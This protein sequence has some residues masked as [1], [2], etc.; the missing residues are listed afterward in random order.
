MRPNPRRKGPADRILQ[1]RIVRVLRVKDTREY[2]EGPDGKF[3]P[4]PGSGEARDC[5]RCGREHR[6]HAEVELEDHS[7]AI[8]GTGC[9]TQ[10]EMDVSKRVKAAERVA[11]RIRQTEAELAKARDDLERYQA[12]LAEVE[13]LERPYLRDHQPWDSVPWL[14]MG[15]AKV[16]L[17][18]VRTGRDREERERAVLQQWLDNRMA[19]RG[20][21]RTGAHTLKSEVSRLEDVLERAERQLAKSLEA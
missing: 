11:K 17:Q 8:V 12:D 1:P 5:D 14:V 3:H 10:S 4:V 16:S 18:F 13:T 7:I 9:M 6:V 2:E 20:W 15:D 21:I 19:E